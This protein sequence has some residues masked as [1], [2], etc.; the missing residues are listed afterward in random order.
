MK[1]ECIQIYIKTLPQKKVKSF[2]TA[3]W[4]GKLVKSMCTLTS[5]ETSNFNMVADFTEQSGGSANWE[6]LDP[7]QLYA[8]VAAKIA[9]D[10]FRKT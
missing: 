9:R 2:F 8:L 3:V 7:T 5:V 4:E 10:E 6:N 1:S